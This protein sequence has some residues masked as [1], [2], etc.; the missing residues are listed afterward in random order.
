MLRQAQ[1]KICSRRE[2]QGEHYL[3]G[4][5]AAP[6]VGM[7]TAVLVTPVV[8]L[9]IVPDRKSIDP[10]GEEKRFHSAI[11]QVLSELR[12]LGASLQD[13]ALDAERALFEAYVMML[14][15][16]SIVEDT[17][18]CIRAG[19]W[20]P[21]ALRET[22]EQHAKV[23]D[24]MN[25]PYLRERASD[26][27]GLGHRILM[28]LEAQ[29]ITRTE[30]P[31]SSV[32]IGE[33]I[34][35]TDLAEVPAGRLGGVVSSRGSALSHVA[36]LARTL[37]V[38]AVMGLGYTHLSHFHGKVLV[39]D[40]YSGRIYIEP[41]PEVKRDF[42]RLVREER[43]LAE[44]LKVFKDLPAETLDGWRLPL[45]TNSGMLE[46]IAPS[47]NAGSDG[48]GLFRTE[49]PFIVRDRFPT[50]KEQFDIYRHILKSF[51]PRPVTLRTLDAG[52]DKALPYFPVSESNPFLGW[53]GLRMTL[54]HPDIF[55]VQLRAA[56]R[57]SKG[58][59]NLK[60]LLPMVTTVD[61]V[62][63]ALGLIE[64]SKEEL[65]EEG[66]VVTPPIGVMI[67]V[68]AA[69]IEAEFLARH[70]DFLSIGTNDL[71]QY[72]LAVDRSNEKVA[73]LFEPLHPAILKTI[74][75]VV[76]GGHR[77]GKPV[78]VCGESASDP[79]MALLLL[80][81][82]IDHLSVGVSD[83]PRIKWLVRSFTRK[84]TCELLN[85]ALEKAHAKAIRKMLEETLQAAGLQGLVKAGS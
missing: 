2:F 7:G 5:A 68:P 37:G 31:Q 39:V 23:F 19:N 13:T 76:E 21:G 29:A 80:G 48:V 72:L 74:K 47:L 64:Q 18:R 34:T 45:Y 14:E 30:F 81:M 11:G 50:E 36:I 9:E 56:M 84:K 77:A 38:P 70:V 62:E 28:H 16:G 49:I 24:Q 51:A 53:R 27:R 58:L 75:S 83:V 26:I 79:L 25:D 17:V 35:A 20:A 57:A 60:L 43:D 3:E 71:I 66:V 40:G 52:G 65:R 82:G 73:R 54:D 41:R 44:Q 4:V 55:L 15:G 85:S 1:I 69:A 63:E 12:S 10:T 46:G 22:I 67:E 78:G 42:R 33:E 8:R 59:D 61:E 6:G 32:L